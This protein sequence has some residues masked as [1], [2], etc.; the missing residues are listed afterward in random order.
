MGESQLYELLLKINSQTS[1]M[2]ERVN[3]VYSKVD[4]IDGRLQ[5]IEVNYGQRISR[6]EQA[7][8]DWE[9]SKSEHFTLWMILFTLANLLI[10]VMG[11]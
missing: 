6:L 8:T 3:E 7:H 10:A 2:S 5:K 11:R 1:T 4:D 9:G